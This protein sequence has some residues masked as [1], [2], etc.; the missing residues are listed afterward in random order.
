MDQSATVS[1]RQ[2]GDLVVRLRL[3]TG[4]DDHGLRSHS[5]TPARGDRGR[6]WASRL[7]IADGVLY[8][9]SGSRIAAID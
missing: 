1:V 7:G 2:Y 3:A 6:R 5:T 9:R 8:V 4:H